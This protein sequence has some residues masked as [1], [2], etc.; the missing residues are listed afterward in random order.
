MVIKEELP[1]EGNTLGARFVLTI[2]NV[3]TNREIFKARFLVQGHTACQQNVL[4]HTATNVAQKSIRMLI[5]I[6]S[7]FGYGIWTQGILQAYLQSA[8]KL[9]TEVH[10]IPKGGFSLKSNQLLIY[11]LNR[12]MGYPTAGGISMLE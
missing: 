6:V 4:V 10:I 5:A 11:A 2:K 3:G 9:T 7:I 8:S 12:Y 1:G